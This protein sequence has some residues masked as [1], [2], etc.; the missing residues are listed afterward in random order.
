MEGNYGSHLGT[1]DIYEGVD[2]ADQDHEFCIRHGISAGY[3][4]AK[5]SESCKVVECARAEPLIWQKWVDISGRVVEVGVKEGR[6]AGGCDILGSATAW[7][8][9]AV[10]EESDGFRQER[11]RPSHKGVQTRL[12]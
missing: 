7:C 1:F 5:L 9:P 4:N 6:G 10:P 12:F 11:R 8:A 3:R 2:P